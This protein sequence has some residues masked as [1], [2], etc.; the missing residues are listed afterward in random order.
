MKVDFQGHINLD[1]R[2]FKRIVTRLKIYVRRN[3]LPSV[4]ISSV[5]SLHSVAPSIVLFM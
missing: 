5:S 2:I 4:C 3:E 1:D